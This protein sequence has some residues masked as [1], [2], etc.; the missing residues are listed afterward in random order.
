MKAFVHDQDVNVTSFKI[1]LSFGVSFGYICLSLSSV[2]MFH[3]STS[4]FKKK[5]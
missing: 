1:V 3:I 5:T 4:M 2:D